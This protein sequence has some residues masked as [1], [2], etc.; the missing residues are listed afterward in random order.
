MVTNLA[1]VVDVDELERLRSR[2]RDDRVPRR[3]DRGQLVPLQQETMELD[4]LAGPADVVDDSSSSHPVDQSIAARPTEAARVCRNIITASS[5]RSQI[6]LRV[7]AVFGWRAGGGLRDGKFVAREGDSCR[8]V[9][10]GALSDPETGHN[11]GG[12]TWLRSRFIQL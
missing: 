3:L 12:P 6:R 9:T 7:G 5:L 10:E 11:N 4:R 2:L 8:R 1:L